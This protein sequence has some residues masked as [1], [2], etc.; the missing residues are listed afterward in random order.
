MTRVFKRPV[1]GLAHLPT[2]TV[3]F[4]HAPK[5]GRGS[6]SPWRGSV[7]CAFS[8]AFSSRGC[9][10]GS[11]QLH[12]RKPPVPGFTLGAGLA[13]LCTC[14]VRDDDV[15]VGGLLDVGRG[16][17]R[18]TVPAASSQQAVSK[19]SAHG[20]VRK[21][22]DTPYLQPTTAH[23]GPPRPTTAHHGP[24]RHTTAHHGTPRHREIKTSR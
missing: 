18:H 12:Q 15:V 16:G 24:P 6:R 10:V 13:A 19:Q 5:L 14:N 1:S 9:H 2:G 8:P 21:G 7:P 22:H 17:A 3:A 11:P 20:Q 23:H 4:Y